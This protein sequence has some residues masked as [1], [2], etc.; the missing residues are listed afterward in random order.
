MYG[1]A[2]SSQQGKKLQHFLLGRVT[3]V[4]YVCLEQGQAFIESAES[5]TQIP[6][7]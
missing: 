4:P 5:S 3:K 1:N 6:V 7:E 2:W